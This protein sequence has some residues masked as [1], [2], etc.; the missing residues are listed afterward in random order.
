MSQS[1]PNASTK[2]LLSNRMYDILKQAA[3]F[4]FPA[5]IALYW[6]LAQVW[7]FPNAEQVMGTL[8]AIN[9]FI[10]GLIGRS[11]ASYK[12]SGAKYAGVIN[13]SDGDSK[14]TASMDLNGPA[15]ELLQQSEATFKITPIPISTDIR[16]SDGTRTS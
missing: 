9:V 2:P 5:C 16:S 8:A 7:H 6:A 12:S 1:I 14:I 13:I 3:S 10:G 11:S 4:G 15:E